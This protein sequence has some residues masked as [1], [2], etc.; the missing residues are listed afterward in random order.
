MNQAIR[1]D[2]KCMQTKRQED[3]PKLKGYKERYKEEN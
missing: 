1:I 3:F 2:K